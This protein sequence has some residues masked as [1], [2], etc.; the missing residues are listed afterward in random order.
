MG[1]YALLLFFFVWFSSISL[2]CSPIQF[3]FAFFMHLLSWCY[4]SL[5][6]ISQILKIQIFSFSVLPFCCTDQE[7]LLRSR[8]FFFWQSLPRISLAVSVTAVMKVVII[9]SMSVSLLLMMVGGANF[10]P[11]IAWKVPNSLGSFSFSRSNLSPSNLVLINWQKGLWYLRVLALCFL[12]FFYRG[13]TE[14]TNSSKNLFDVCVCCL[15]YICVRTDFVDFWE[16][17]VWRLV[18]RITTRQTE[19][20]F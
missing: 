20:C 13:T 9:D 6:S 7:F 5:P 1:W 17:V 18:C 12:V 8:F 15:I 14:G 3:S 19:V 2:H 11:I 16:F 4:G 10:P